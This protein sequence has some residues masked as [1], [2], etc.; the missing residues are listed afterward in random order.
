MA[1]YEEVEKKDSLINTHIDKKGNSLEIGD[2]VLLDDPPFRQEIV[3]EGFT[4]CPTNS[5]TLNQFSRIYGK[6]TETLGNVPCYCVE[7]I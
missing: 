5:D 4:E 6:G 7:K 2:R 1:W 3:I